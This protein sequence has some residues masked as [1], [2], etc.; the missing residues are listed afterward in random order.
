MSEQRTRVSA[1]RVRLPDVCIVSA[2]APFERVTL[3]PPLI[4]IEILSSEDRLPRVVQRLDD[5]LQMG[6]PNLWLLDPLE[7]IAFT[8]SQQG[9]RKTVADRITVPN[10]PIYLDLPEIFAALD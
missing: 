5:F 4:A 9:L 6:V 7:R 8:Y 10:T 3:T 2:D 1:D